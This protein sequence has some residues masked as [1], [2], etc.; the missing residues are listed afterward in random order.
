MDID[1]NPTQLTSNQNLSTEDDVEFNSETVQSQS[2]INGGTPVSP[3]AG[4]LKI[5]SKLNN[6]IYTLNSLGQ[7]NELGGGGGGSGSPWAFST[8]TSGIPAPGQFF[9]NNAVPASVTD[10]VISKTDSDGN[11]QSPLLQTLAMGDTLLLSNFDKSNQKLYL[12]S[13]LVAGINF[14][15]ISVTQEAQ[16]L[17][18]NYT[19]TE[20]IN[21]VFYIAQNPFDQSLNTTDNVTFNDLTVST[22][23]TITPSL[24]TDNET[25]ITALNA[26]LRTVQN[27]VNPAPGGSVLVG[28]VN[29][30]PIV[31]GANTTVF[32]DNVAALLSTGASNTLIGASAVNALTT[33]SSNSAIGYSCM[34][35]LTIGSGNT[36]LGGLGGY[37]IDTGSNNVCLGYLAHT[38]DTA[39]INR[40]ALG[41]NSAAKTDNSCVIGNTAIASVVP[42]NPLCELGTVAD[43]FGAVTCGLVNTVDVLALSQDAGGISQIVKTAADSTLVGE[44]IGLVATTAVGNVAMGK[45]ALEGVTSG[46]YNV[47]LGTDCMKSLTIGQVNT[48]VG[49]R[50]LENFQSGNLNTVIGM[51]SALD[52]ISGSNNL[53][54]GS[55]SVAG[56]ATSVNRIVIGAGAIGTA[57]FQCKIGT[58]QLNSIVPHPNATCSLGTALE[59]FAEVH[60][61]GVTV[62]NG[63]G[64]ASVKTNVLEPIN[65]LGP[66]FVT[67]T[68]DVTGNVVLTG[69]VIATGDVK[70]EGTL[71]VDTI[72]SFDGISNIEMSDTVRITGDLIVTNSIDSSIITGTSRV[73]TASLRDLTQTTRVNI[74]AVSVDVVSTD[75]LQNGV[76]ITNKIQNINPST[77]LGNTVLNGDLAVSTIKSIAQQY[78]VNEDYTTANTALGTTFGDAIVGVSSN[79]LQLSNDISN[80][81]GGL[82]FTGA[83]PLSCTVEYD[84]LYLDPVGPGGTIE[85]GNA[86]AF[87][88]G[89][90]ASYTSGFKWYSNPNGMNYPCTTFVPDRV[91]ILGDG[92]DSGYVNVSEFILGQT[93]RTKLVITPTL[94]SFYVDNVLKAT[95]VSTGQIQRSK[96]G[97]V[98]HGSTNR[99][100]NYFIK[101]LQVY[102]AVQAAATQI[103][104][105]TEISLTGDTSINGSFTVNSVLQ[106]T[107]RSIYGQ[108]STGSVELTTINLSNAIQAYTIDPSLIAGLTVTSFSSVGLSEGLNEFGFNVSD[109]GLYEVHIN[110]G[111]KPNST[112]GALVTLGLLKNGIVTDFGSSCLKM[113]TRFSNQTVSCLIQC[114][115]LDS[116]QPYLSTFGGGQSDDI[117]VKFICFNVKRIKIS[118]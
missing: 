116:L 63:L 11:D 83:L 58:A 77:T 70:L 13:D 57:D 29:T 99:S 73:I 6:K 37:D 71:K 101:N 26:N 31:T 49:Y 7:E 76:S 39:S 110:C 113:K 64:T 102:D 19:N 80:S 59:P 79:G 43:P 15:S 41:H 84:W 68:L 14:Y 33:G 21:M 52:L 20:T 109:A 107:A 115:A 32:G 24:I 62:T 74:D 108:Q 44:L 47:A 54:I 82:V 103:D 106:D 42:G 55:N 111:I 105:G 65:P 46:Q 69:N 56:G 97:V 45:R 86:I 9:Y 28:G 61:S 22:I 92:G 89:D 85:D 117:G 112:D 90:L 25:Q 87:F 114:N 67:K 60:C 51:N 12:V 98:G 93:Y 95:A 96:F 53:V 91:R 75:L 104:L 118:V 4:E 1:G 48:G 18:T 72:T 23:N 36:A 81:G 27:L 30:A 40:I 3:P 2:F 35:N 16:S 38:G 50:C 8:A 34:S 10:I 88:T 66:I 94:I 17:P 5:Y 100:C 78:I